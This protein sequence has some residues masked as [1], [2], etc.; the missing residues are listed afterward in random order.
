MIH[1]NRRSLAA[2]TLLEIMIALTV[3]SIVM[4]ALLFTLSRMENISQQQ[5]T[6]S[7][8]QQSARAAHDEIVRM[9]RMA[10]RGGLQQDRGRLGRA[11]V[12]RNNAGIGAEPREVVTGVS[13]PPMAMEGTDIL[14]VRGV[15]NSE[16]VA[17]NYRDPTTS[18]YDDSTGI[19]FVTIPLTTPTGITQDLT[20][21]IDANNDGLEEALVLI[22][23]IDASTYGVARLIP[24]GSIAD[25]ATEIRLQFDTQGGRGPDYAILSRDFDGDAAFPE[26][27]AVAFVGVLEEYRF[28]I[29]DDDDLGPVMSRA[30]V[31]PNT[32]APWN[33]DEDEVQ[34]DYAIG[35]VDL[36]VALAF[37]STIEGTFDDDN[38]AT[39][40]DDVIAEYDRDSSTDD[41]WLFNQ[42]A[43]DATEA[44]W[45]GP[46]LPEAGA[47]EERP[48][49]F[50][51]RVSTLAMARGIER[52]HP[53]ELIDGLEDRD[54]GIGVDDPINGHPNRSKRKRLLTTVIKP[55]NL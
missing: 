40:P 26:L 17:V 11:I 51:I 45:S 16:L 8:V 46:W 12:V 13:D 37:D 14:T 18:S 19:G 41:D 27:N 22:D 35:I 36:Q 1:E 4:T 2:F 23:A 50:A 9:T 48:S 6:I 15:M 54:Y 39:G 32:D 34:V 29:R 28:Y 55:R 3:L 20:A 21:L 24:G 52:G 47:I 42:T 31:F 7:E 25:D 49:L 10:G 30:R 5:I 43:D 33:D 44:L 53:S 38:N